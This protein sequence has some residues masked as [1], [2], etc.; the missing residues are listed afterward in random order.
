MEQDY[1]KDLIRER[2][3]YNPT[4]GELTWKER[5]TSL[6]CHKWF[7]ETK[8]D[9]PCG[10]ITKSK[11]DGYIYHGIT[12]EDS[13]KRYRFGAARIAWLLMT[14]G[15]PKHTVDHINRD[16]TDHR[17]EN[18]RDVTQ[19]VNNQNRGRYACN[20]LNYKGVYFKYGKYQA[21][22]TSNY[23]RYSLG[24]YD[25]PEEAAKAYDAKAYEVLGDEAKLNFVRQNNP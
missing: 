12:L 5:D 8:A 17:W 15:W 11:K 24:A 13:G 3:D 18:L 16:S 6:I 21:I 4:T 14:G 9:K 1:L 19:S 2:I 7:N 10:N 23:V 22:F 25:T 20:K